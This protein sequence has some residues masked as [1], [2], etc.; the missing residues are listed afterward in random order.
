MKECKSI[1]ALH[2]SC[3]L[4]LS[5]CLT[6]NLT[7]KSLLCASERLDPEV[8]RSTA[9]AKILI[10]VFPFLSKTCGKPNKHTCIAFSM[11]ILSLVRAV[12]VCIHTQKLVH[13]LQP[14]L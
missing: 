2:M 6:R 8:L 5:S 7:S 10:F 11:K 14:S 4:A 9:S 12:R 1:P 3:R 13:C